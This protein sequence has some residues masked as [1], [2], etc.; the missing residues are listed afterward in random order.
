MHTILSNRFVLVTTQRS[1][2]TFF[3]T[4]LESHPQIECPGTI[5][6]QKNRLKYF[7]IDR[8]GSY[9][10]AYRT[11]TL[12]RRIAHWFDRTRIV[13]ACLDEAYSST[14]SEVALGFKISYSN[15]ERYPSIVSWLHE[16]DVKVIHWFRDNLL[17][18]HISQLTMAARGSAHFSRPVRKVTINVDPQNLLRDLKRQ[19]YLIDKYRAIFKPKGEA[20]GYIEMFYE[21]FVKNQ[22][23][24]AQRILHFLGVDE[25]IPLRSPLVKQNPDDLQ[26]IISNY[27]EVARALNGTRFERFLSL[28]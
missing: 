7:S 23:G 2:A 8:K 12:K 22:Q 13:H 11:R 6:A 24:E 28:N 9:Y 27:S 15:F 14:N 1:G 5:F 20:H 17:K 4:C 16:H 26:E 25:S 18:R 10:H 3:R 19:S 21:S